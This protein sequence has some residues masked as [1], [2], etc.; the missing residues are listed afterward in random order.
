[1]RIN[2]QE[3]KEYRSAYR[4]NRMLIKKAPIKCN[5]QGKHN[6]FHINAIETR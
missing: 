3:H 2:G 4:K 6:G 1:M 5:E